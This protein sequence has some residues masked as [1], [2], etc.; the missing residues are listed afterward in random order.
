MDEKSTAAWWHEAVTFP[1]EF[2][3]AAGEGE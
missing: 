2:S 3:Y 1:E